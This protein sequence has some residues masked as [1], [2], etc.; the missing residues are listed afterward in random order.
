MT[1]AAAG[2][3]VIVVASRRIPW[4]LAAY[5]VGVVVLVVCSAGLPALKTRFLLPD[6]A[7][8]LPIAAGFAHRRTVTMVASASVF[9]LVGAWYSAYSL[10]VWKYAI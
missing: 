7:L 9:V 2:L 5:A 4:Q 10:T 8:L 6:F 3:A 1:L